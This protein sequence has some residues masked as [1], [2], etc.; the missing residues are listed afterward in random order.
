M[1]LAALERRRLLLV[2]PV[3][4]PDPHGSL[5]GAGAAAWLRTR[6]KERATWRTCWSTPCCSR[7]AAWVS[8]RCS[9]CR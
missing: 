5:P 3:P 7:R 4:L 2:E 8:S 9:G 1:P 6:L